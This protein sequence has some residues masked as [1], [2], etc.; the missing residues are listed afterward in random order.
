VSPAHDQFTDL[1]RAE[2]TASLIFDPYLG[3]WDRDANRTGTP[4]QLIGR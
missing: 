4:I 1:I 2:A 3:A